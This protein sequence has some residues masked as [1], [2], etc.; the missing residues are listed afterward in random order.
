MHD[1]QWR[2]PLDNSDNTPK[3][4]KDQHSLLFNCGSRYSNSLVVPAAF[5]SS[6]LLRIDSRLHSK[7]LFP[8]ILWDFTTEAHWQ[9]KDAI[10][11]LQTNHKKKSP[12]MTVYLG[13]KTGNG[14]IISMPSWLFWC[15]CTSCSESSMQNLTLYW[16]N[17]Y[18][19]KALWFFLSNTVFWKLGRE[20]VL[21]FIYL[22]FMGTLDICLLRP[23]V[24]TNSLIPVAPLL[25][26]S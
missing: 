18:Q 21:F 26:F 16:A 9:C 20:R 17:Q 1:R 3:E 25:S 22:R 11:I 6:S 23:C 15:Q 14:G 19:F 7:I 24:P 4:R 10:V 12:W 2:F 5:S 13:V 8:S